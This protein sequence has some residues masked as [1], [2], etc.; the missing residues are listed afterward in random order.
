MDGPGLT[1]LQS[2]GCFELFS[3]YIM[4]LSK[5]GHQGHLLNGL[6]DT[7][8]RMYSYIAAITETLE[9]MEAQNRSERLVVCPCVTLVAPIHAL[10]SAHPDM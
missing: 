2:L 6:K 9:T 10:P 3:R 7:L 5:Q 4:V 8:E 1:T